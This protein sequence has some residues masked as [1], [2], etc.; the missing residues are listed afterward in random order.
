MYIIGAT[1]RPDII[2]KAMLRPGRLE[3]IL[4]VPLPNE[5]DRVDILGKHLK[6][7]PVDLNVNLKEIALN[8]KCDRFSGADIS[9]LVKEAQANCVRRYNINP[10][11]EQLLLCQ[12]DF[13]FAMNKIVPSV[14]KKDMLTYEKVIILVIYYKI[15]NL[16]KL[17]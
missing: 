11:K 16:S 6:K 8:P 10:S 14:S 13:D 2:E 3:K 17:F 5:Q 12:S 7:V 15:I 1:N 9:S 4:Y